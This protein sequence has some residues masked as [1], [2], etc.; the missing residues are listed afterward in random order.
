MISTATRKDRPSTRI[1]QSKMRCQLISN[2][3]L[4]GFSFYDDHKFI[5]GSALPARRFSAT[6][7]PQNSPPSTLQEPERRV[8]RMW[9]DHHADSPPQSAQAKSNRAELATEWR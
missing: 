7:R 4:F 3:S 8:C 5:H 1:M 6:V 2:E 9:I